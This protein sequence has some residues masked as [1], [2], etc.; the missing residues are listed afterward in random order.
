MMREKPRHGRIPSSNA[1]K[2][3]NQAAASAIREVIDAL[4]TV[5]LFLGD[6]IRR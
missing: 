6:R 5:L 2:L 1:T 4:M 3:R